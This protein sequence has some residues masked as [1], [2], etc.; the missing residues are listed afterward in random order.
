MNAGRPVWLVV[1]MEPDKVIIDCDQCERQMSFPGVR[2][3]AVYLGEDIAQQH[4]RLANEEVN[5][6]AAEHREWL[7][8]SIGASSSGPPSRVNQWD[9]VPTGRDGVYYR[10]V[11]SQLWL[12]PDQYQDHRA[13]T[14]SQAAT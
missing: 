11:E 9:R 7:S 6:I 10:V 12:H 5:R 13:E 2:V 3:V 8:T 4:A 1:C 14:T